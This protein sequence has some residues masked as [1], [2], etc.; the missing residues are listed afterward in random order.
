MPRPLVGARDPVSTLEAQLGAAAGDGPFG[1]RAAVELDEAD[2][3]PGEQYALLDGW[4][5]A[6]HYVPA[7][8]G[9]QLTSFETLGR[10]VRA[11]ARHN[12]S[13][14]VGHAITFLG[15]VTVWAFGS[16]AQKRRLAD[17][18]RGDGRVALA[19][20]EKEHGSDFLA[21]DTQ[22]VRTDDGLRLTGEKWLVNAATESAA[23]TTF[24]ACAD[25]SAH[26]EGA[27]L[28]LIKD[29]LP[30]AAF[31]H[32]PR[33]RPL[34]VRGVDFSGI[35]FADC[36]VPPDALVGVEGAGL[37][38]TLTAFQITRALI[39]GLSLGALEAGLDLVRAFAAQRRLYGDGMLAMPYVRSVL[40]DVFGD[41][42][43]AEAVQRAAARAAHVYPADLRLWSA[44]CKYV[45]PLVAEDALR[46]LGEILGARA[47]LREEHGHG[48]FQKIVRDHAVVRIFHGGGF[49]LLQTIGLVRGQASAPGGEAERRALVQLGGPLPPFDWS[50]LSATGA[51]EPALVLDQA[52][53]AA[54]ETPARE[55][56]EET[57]DA[58]RQLRSLRAKT[59][60]TA[61]GGGLSR[62]FY[63][64]SARRAFVHAAALAG[65]VALEGDGDVPPAGAL[66][67]GIDRLLSRAFP[68]RD[69]PRR[70]EL[71][72]RAYEELAAQAIVSSPIGA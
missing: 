57:L 48:M 40:A 67:L 42:A 5:L 46:T 69:A 3:R 6:E 39:P 66:A 50:R 68:G 37:A 49:Q 30:P 32:T 21:A 63:D 47:Y 25:R 20:H 18:I 34:G 62:A 43:A 4:G 53:A 71:A 44:V 23:L 24:V 55:L 2:A 36:P 17:L 56:A 52:L 72:E 33:V 60:S 65:L 7:A 58:A 61:A 35:A 54:R 29:D 1:Y 10:L 13:V 59:R 38:Q 11:V 28:L 31:R 14:A 8:L 12:L 9:G 51:V 70:P 19:Y 45:V 22:L 15:S 64:L 26:P 27:I 16:D 41:L